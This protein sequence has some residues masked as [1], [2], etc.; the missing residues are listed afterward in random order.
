MR[1][2][3]NVVDGVVFFDAVLSVPKLYWVFMKTKLLVIIEEGKLCCELADKAL[4]FSRVNLMQALNSSGT[5]MTRLKRKA[6]WMVAT[7]FLSASFCTV[8]NFRH[9]TSTQNFPN[10]ISL[11]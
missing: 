6:S 7:L 4:V 2:V 3:E 1:V 10:I 8:Y 9:L 5:A 11:R